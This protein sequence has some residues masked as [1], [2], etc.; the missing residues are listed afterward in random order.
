MGSQSGYY[1][2]IDEPFSDEELEA[3]MHIAE[4]VKITVA[5]KHFLMVL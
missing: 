5:S 1:N 3:I 2:Y 4:A